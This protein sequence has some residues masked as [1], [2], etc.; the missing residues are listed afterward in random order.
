[1]GDRS[2]AITQAAR[3]YRRGLEDFRGGRFREAARHIRKAVDVDPANVDWRLA[4]G[5]RRRGVGVVPRFPDLSRA[6]GGR[7]GGAL[8]KLARSRRRI[9]GRKK[10]DGLSGIKR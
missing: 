2:P 4:L 5:R 9:S 1:M 7:L 10:G 6:P 8:A 3:H